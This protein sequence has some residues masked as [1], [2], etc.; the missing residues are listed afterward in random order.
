MALSGAVARHGI[1]P[2]EAGNEVFDVHVVERESQAV[3]GS[4]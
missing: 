2:E 1:R 3:G 4:E